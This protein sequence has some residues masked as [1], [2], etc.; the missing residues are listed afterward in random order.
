MEIP[1]RFALF[2]V[3]RRRPFCYKS[4]RSWLYP[5]VNTEHGKDSFLCGVLEDGNDLVCQLELC[6]S[7]RYVKTDKSIELLYN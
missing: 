4:A 7:Q 5:L 2:P 1:G 6:A 3:A